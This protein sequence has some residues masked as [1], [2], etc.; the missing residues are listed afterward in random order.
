MVQG[1]T[2]GGNF[3]ILQ[4]HRSSCDEYSFYIER[5][6]FANGYK[7]GHSVIYK[8]NISNG[9]VLGIR[10]ELHRIGVSLWERGQENTNDRIVKRQSETTGK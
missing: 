10:K 6:I 1:L 2:T 5:G 8:D 3:L 9:Y 7:S 4:I